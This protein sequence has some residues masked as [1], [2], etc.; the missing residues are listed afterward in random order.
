MLAAGYSPQFIRPQN[1]VGYW[2]LFGRAGASGGEEAWVGS[3]SFTANDSPALV[4]HPRIIYPHSR[5]IIAVPQAA[6]GA[7]TLGAA[8]VINITATGATP[9]LT[10][11]W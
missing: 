10:A 8:S 9:R 6:S 1:L 5:G 3:A 11:T 4:D 7:P 2:P